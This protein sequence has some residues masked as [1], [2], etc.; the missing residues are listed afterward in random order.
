MIYP[1]KE[2]KQGMEIQV[3]YAAIASVLLQ[4]YDITSTFDESTHSKLNERFCKAIVNR[5]SF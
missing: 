2:L 5:N 4:F 1:R 3:F